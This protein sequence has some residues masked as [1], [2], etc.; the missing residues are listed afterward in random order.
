MSKQILIWNNS[1]D[2]DFVNAVADK[3]NCLPEDGELDIYLSST[4]G[5]VAAEKMLL[6][7][8]ENRKKQIGIFCTALLHSAAF[9]LFFNAKCYR[10][11]VPGIVGMYHS[12]TLP[13]NLNHHGNPAYH[14]GAAYKK[15]L[16]TD[17]KVEA[18]Y[19]C[20]YLEMT[21]LQKKKVMGG[22][23]VFFTTEEMQKFLEISN[24]KNLILIENP[25]H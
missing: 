8:I 4:G 11:I 23:D 5:L 15:L 2:F 16:M 25:N 10:K 19:M 6:D 18:E 13:I 22:Y 12:A 1:I 14:D 9:S 7:I 20:D 24:K 21:P 17:D 3:L